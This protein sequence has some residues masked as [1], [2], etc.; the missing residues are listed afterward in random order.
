MQINIIYFTSTGNTLWLASKTKEIIEQQGHEVKLY[1]VI[2]DGENFIKDKCDMLGVFFPVWDYLPAVPLWNFLRNEMPEGKN[3]KIFFIGDCAG[4]AG[5]VSMMC[6]KL[7]DSK[8][9]DAFYF[10]HIIMTTNL[11][12][13][14]MPFN[15]WK[16]APKPKQ[17]EKILST[18]EKQLQKIC[19]SVLSFEA[20][21]EAT[22]ILWNIAGRIQRI[23]GVAVNYYKK[24]FS[25]A[26][27]RC[28]DCGLCSR[29]CP[30]D[31]ISKN[32]DGKIV[33]GYKCI[34][35]AK[36]YNLCPKDA[37]LI[38][39]KTINNKKYTRYKGPDHKIKPVSYRK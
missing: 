13:P 38:G 8:G 3:K 11:V 23:C 26:E 37:V 1:E 20:R 4:I 7:M 35:C 25:I 2:K 33:F 18:A 32:M 34:M 17:L 29:I 27:D 9:Y 10:N 28:I 14:W 12:V 22:G 16:K 39:K 36:C 30:T 5:D 31:N 19:E 15:L 21:F 24:G 6:K